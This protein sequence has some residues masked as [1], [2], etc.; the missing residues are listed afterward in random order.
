MSLKQCRAF[1]SVQCRRTYS[2]TCNM[3]C[4]FMSFNFMSVNFMP[5]HFDGPS[6]S[7]PS[8]S[9]PPIA[10][11]QSFAAV[12]TARPSVL[13]VGLLTQKPHGSATA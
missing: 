7:R 12:L 2:D 11:R 3:S 6:F 4:I 13:Q 10:A 8:F 1:Y 9:A 5:G